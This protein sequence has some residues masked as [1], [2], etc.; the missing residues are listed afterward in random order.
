MIRFLSSFFIV[1]FLM[2]EIASAQVYKRPDDME[3]FKEKEPPT[4]LDA[5]SAYI[6][7]RLGKTSKKWAPAP[8][9]IRELTATEAA[10][11]D[12]VK[13]EKFTKANAK[14]EKKRTKR[15]E[16]KAKAEK[17]GEP[18]TKT[19]PGVLNYEQFS[20]EYEPV[21]NVYVT[22]PQKKYRK[23][24][25]GRDLF[26]SVKPGRYVLFNVGG[27]CMCLGTV[28]FDVKAGVVTDLGMIVSD[29]AD[30]DG[31]VSQYQEIEMATKDHGVYRTGFPYVASAVRPYSETMDFPA[32][33]SGLNRVGVEY[34]AKGQ[35]PLYFGTMIDRIPAIPGILDYRD[36]KV[37]D[38]R[39]GQVVD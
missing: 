1:F 4:A 16:E 12:V 9:F 34:Q 10:D 39:T 7:V 38:A 30:R 21:S 20:F 19:V 32:E 18:Y 5:E 26:F 13:R 6:F 17:R 24:D 3:Y 27:V 33:L 14:N 2:S 37:V 29:L 15:L 11:Y 28:E 35:L 25:Y 23:T 31:E 22:I 36:G 8:T